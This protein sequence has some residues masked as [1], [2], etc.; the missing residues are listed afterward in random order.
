[1]SS[2]PIAASEQDK[3]LRST[4]LDECEP[5]PGAIRG[6][7][8][9]SY[10]VQKLGAEIVAGRYQ[11]GDLLAT[12]LTAK[13]DLNVSRGVYRESIRALAA[14]GLVR[15]KTKVGTCVTDASQWTLLDPHVLRWLQ[16]AEKGSR[17][18]IELLELC[19]N[20]EP[21]AASMA[22]ARR[23]HRDMVALR[24]ACST[25]ARHPVVSNASRQ[26]EIRLHSALLKATHNTFFLSLD[27]AIHAAIALHF[28]APGTSQDAQLH[29][30]VVDAICKQRSKAAILET[31]T[32]WKRLTNA[33]LDAEW[34]ND[35][36]HALGRDE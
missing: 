15:S 16:S 25:L 27:S 28:P 18:A 11:V 9:Q 26:A 6:H 35:S 14:K 30:H 1:M 3:E 34:V 2:P 13:A 8:Q 21:I 20:I 5:R 4:S 19:R 32:L 22:A 33:T 31:Q 10:L 36:M 24:D 29:L 23:E 17:L 12:E 7:G